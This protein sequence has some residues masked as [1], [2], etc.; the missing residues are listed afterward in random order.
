MPKELSAIRPQGVPKEII[1]GPG[2]QKVIREW[3]LDRDEI[4]ERFR[5]MGVEVV[6]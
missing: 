4:I 1:L 6:E 3:K 2:I 5:E